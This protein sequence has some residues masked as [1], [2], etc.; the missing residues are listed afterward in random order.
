MPDLTTLLLTDA[1]DVNKAWSEEARE[2]A[3]EARRAGGSKTRADSH[4]ALTRAGWRHDRREGGEDVYHHGTYGRMFVG[5][6]GF[7][8]K[9][10]HGLDQGSGWHSDLPNYLRDLPATTRENAAQRGWR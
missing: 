8:H 2:A 3:A 10:A 1:V 6:E 7:D 4:Q 5:H 9:D